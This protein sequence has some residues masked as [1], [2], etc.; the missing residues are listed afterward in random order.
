MKEKHVIS[1]VCASPGIIKGTARLVRTVDDMNS[2][3]YGDIV[4]LP[5]SHPMYAIAVMKASAV[6]CEIGGKISHICIVAMEMGIP[7][8]TQAADAT[9]LIEN[10]QCVLINANEGI[11]NVFE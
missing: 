2:V 6:I 1:C 7:C 5:A 8:V 4:V 3:E 10:G 11:I 9:K